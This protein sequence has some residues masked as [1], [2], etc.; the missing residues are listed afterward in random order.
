MRISTRTHAFLDLA[1]AGFALAFPRVLGASDRFTRIV[2]T[3]ALGKLAYGLL[4]EHELGLV[5]VLPMKAHLTLDTIAGAAMCVLPFVRDEKENGAVTMCTVGLGLF[6]ISAAPV[7]DTRSHPDG[8][9]VLQDGTATNS[10]QPVE[11]AR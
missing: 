9:I 4:T 3:L 6:D 2:T 5:K 8:G 7:T 10:R 1:T 11:L